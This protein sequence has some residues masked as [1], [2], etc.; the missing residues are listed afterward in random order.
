MTPN[1]NQ[2]IKTLGKES[3][4]GLALFERIQTAEWAQQVTVVSSP[5]T[6]IQAYFL[7]PCRIDDRLT[8]IHARG[9]ASKDPAFYQNL[10]SFAQQ[11]DYVLL[12]ERRYKDNTVGFDRRKWLPVM[13]FTVGMN[14][15]VAAKELADN[16]GTGTAYLALFDAQVTL[17]EGILE[18]SSLNKDLGS[19]PGIASET[20]RDIEFNVTSAMEELSEHLVEDHGLLKASEFNSDDA[21]AAKLAAPVT[22]EMLSILQKHYADKDSDPNYIQSDLK[23]MAAYFAQYPEASALLRALDDQSWKLT[24]TEN[25]FKTDVRGNAFQVYSATIHF[26]SRAAAKLRSHRACDEKLGACVASPADALL[27]EL[28]HAKAALLTPEE[29]IEQGGMNSVIYPYAHEQVVIQGENELYRSMTSV[30]GRLRPHRHSHSGRLAMA[31]CVT[32]IK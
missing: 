32:C 4:L 6:K 1:T 11:Y 27:H 19:K 21:E 18:K 25:T 24:F 2:T 9:L 22:V 13:M 28:L 16:K 8:V 31:D 23:E 29:F 10:Q 12:A 5:K 15:A 7:H 20:L 17:N 14:G 30:D 26:D 3:T